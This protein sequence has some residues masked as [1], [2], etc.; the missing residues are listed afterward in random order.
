MGVRL[1]DPVPSSSPGTSRVPGS[2]FRRSS[3]PY[4][5]TAQDSPAGSGNRCRRCGSPRHRI[6]VFRVS[7][8]CRRPGG[9]YR[10]RGQ[11]L[12]PY[13]DKRHQ[14]EWRSAHPDYAR[15]INLRRNYGITLEDFDRMAT[16]QDGRCAICG[17]VP[18][19]KH[20]QGRLHVD[21]DHRTGRVRGLLCSHCNRGLGFLGDSPETLCRAA[22][23]LTDGG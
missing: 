20:N 14:A 12:V 8:D 17:R 9:H 3:G 16:V 4:R 10:H 22:A 11:G 13:K 5:V 2:R 6:L 23:Y 7:L 15:D 21:H 1:Q 19:G 18:Q